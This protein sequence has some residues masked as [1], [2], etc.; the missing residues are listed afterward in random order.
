MAL[1]TIDYSKTHKGPVRIYFGLAVPAA[2]AELT[3]DA[4]G[5][6][7]ATENPLAKMVGLTENGA[8]IS[9]TKTEED[10]FFDEY[11]D[12]LSSTISQTGMTIKTRATQILDHDVLLAATAGLGTNHTVTDIKKIKIGKSTVLNTG[13]AVV[14]PTRADPSLFFVA[15]IYSGHNVSNLE[16][17][18]SRQT[19]TGF[20]LEFRAV[21]IT[22]R[23][24]TDRV[25]AIWWQTA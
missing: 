7:D 9:L 10:E 4:S 3:L 20:D 15:H 2:D 23:A 24:D 16:I 8:V 18:N 11:E 14:A 5:V 21:A 6:P 19:R 13:I 17:P 1:N 25:G 12:P 22:S